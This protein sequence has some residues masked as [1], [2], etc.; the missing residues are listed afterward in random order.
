[1]R[2]KKEQ[3]QPF[4]I[5]MSKQS[6]SQ[7][8]VI[9]WDEVGQFIEANCPATQI[10]QHLGIDPKTLYNRCQIDLGITYSALSRQ[11]KSSG[12]AKLKLAAFEAA[13]QGSHDPRFTG[14][15]IFQLKARCGMSD[16]PKEQKAE[17]IRFF[18]DTGESKEQA[19]P[20][21]PKPLLIGNTDSK[22]EN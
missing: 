20:P 14:A 13:L 15:L 16:R 7:L 22:P 9:D 6:L 1:M 18:I 10:A 19:Q 3:V 2:T 11:K 8:A 5:E 17:T 4:E 21:L 12:N